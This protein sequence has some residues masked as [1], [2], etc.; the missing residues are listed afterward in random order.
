M[1]FLVAHMCLLRGDL[2][3]ARITAPLWYTCYSPFSR[4]AVYYTMWLIFKFSTISNREKLC[5]TLTESYWFMFI[6]KD[7][8]LKEP[9]PFVNGE[10]FYQCEWTLLTHQNLTFFF[11]N[12]EHTFTVLLPRLTHWFR[13]W[14]GINSM[15]ALNQLF[16]YMVSISYQLR[17][18]IQFYQFHSV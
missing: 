15:M 2:A 16:W 13:A 17:Y 3:I 6:R 8:H 4:W 7:W 10:S 11:F 14:D 1:K 9:N 18:S 12:L 5:I